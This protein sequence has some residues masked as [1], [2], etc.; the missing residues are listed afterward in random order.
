MHSQRAAERS[1]YTYKKKKNAL[2][3]DFLFLL[4]I[5][6]YPFFLLVS[7]VI[8]LALNLERNLFEV[9]TLTKLMDISYIILLLTI[10]INY[11]N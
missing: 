8:K 10:Y 7:L 1:I 6:F 2:G 3:T 4:F 5:F 9:G 11:I